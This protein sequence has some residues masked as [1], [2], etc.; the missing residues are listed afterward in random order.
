MS[1]MLAILVLA[2]TLF[3]AADPSWWPLFPILIGSLGLGY[4]WPKRRRAP[5][6]ETIIEAARE[7]AEGFLADDC[8]YDHHGYCQSHGLDDAPCPVAR[9]KEALVQLGGS[10]GAGR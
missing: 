2:L 4:F 6:E 5:Q 3:V 7:L 10:T 9:I 8:S 1:A